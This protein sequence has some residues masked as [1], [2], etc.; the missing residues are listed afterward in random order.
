[1]KQSTL[2]PGFLRLLQILSILHVAV[3]LLVRRSLGV[4][5]GIEVPSNGT[6]VIFLAIPVLLVFFTWIPWWR[7]KLGR[8]FVP[9]ILA[10]VSI[11]ILSDKYLTLL[12]LVPP[13]QQELE[14]VM[15]MVRIWF[16]FHIVTL[17]VAWQYSWLW[18]LVATLI[19]SI[20]D[21]ALSLPF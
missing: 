4:R 20:A 9:I 7:Q 11:D 10:L 21:L 17:L 18:T 2:E 13:D 5:L 6:L 3:I 1:M 14:L 19:L 15:L 16:T 12:W 8:S